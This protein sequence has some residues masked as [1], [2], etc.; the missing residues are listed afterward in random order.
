MRMKFPT[1]KTAFVEV[2]DGCLLAL[3]L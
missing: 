2:G 3:C 1:P